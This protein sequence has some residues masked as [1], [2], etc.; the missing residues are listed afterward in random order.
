MLRALKVFF[1]YP[2]LLSILIVTAGCSKTIIREEFTESYQ[3]RPGTMLFIDNPDGSVS[4]TGWEESKV[5][6]KVVKESLSG[7]EALDQVD[8]NIN[9]AETMQ[10]ST[11]HPEGRNLV[12]VDYI[13]SLPID[14]LVAT[15]NCANGDVSLDGITGNPVITTSNGTIT[16]QNVNGMVKAKSINGDI[17]I[18]GARS[19]GD[20]QSSNGTINAELYSIYDNLT[21]K[22]SNGSITLAI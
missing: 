6:V 11:F 13:I 18:S 2:L 12:T 22:T 21:V 1:L 17:N 9:L 3:V 19:L 14:L 4:V 20:L 8:V 10:I 5:E 15:I 16:V 7:R